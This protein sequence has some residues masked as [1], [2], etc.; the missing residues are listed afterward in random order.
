MNELGHERIDLLKLD[1]E[2][3]EYETL[4]QAILDE[5]EFD[6]LCVEFDQPYPFRKTLSFIRKLKK[7]G[8]DPV[9]LDG[10]NVTFIR[11]TALN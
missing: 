1:I 9:A 3:A 2:G 11:R 10:W 5:V 8:L 6:I 4:G 7:N